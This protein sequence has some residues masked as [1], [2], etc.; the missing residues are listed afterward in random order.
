[1]F[2][3]VFLFIDCIIELHLKPFFGYDQIHGESIRCQPVLQEKAQK[4][5]QIQSAV[6]QKIDMLFQSTRCMVT[7]LS[8]S[9]F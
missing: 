9:Q 6:W 4:L 8:N 2:C 1:M 7:F 3:L 5:L